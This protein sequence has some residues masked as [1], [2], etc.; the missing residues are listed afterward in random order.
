MQFENYLEMKKQKTV[1]VE[2][3]G[4]AG[5]GKTTVA[6]LLMNELRKDGYSVINKYRHS[7]LHSKRPFFCI[8]YSFSLY[9]KVKKYAD[10][11]VPY[12]KNR[13]YVHWANH[14]VRMYNTIEKY[15][16]ADFA[17]I[18]EAIIQFIVAMGLNDRFPQSDL[19]DAVVEKIKFM[20]VSFIRVDC[21]NNLEAS[22]ERIKSRPPKGMYYENWPKEELMS[23]LQAETYNF[24]Y[25]RTVF[26][27]V[28]PEQLVIS[29]DTLDS[30]KDNALKI[31]EIITKI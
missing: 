17:I 9:R 28:Y 29:I 18:D 23:Q 16:D 26:S 10:S 4:L 7:I 31:K 11:I 30:P 25:I 2:F 22:Y 6:N 3:N 21:K 20:G 1:I 27:R 14:Y 8:P 15:C 5:L 12:R 13:I 19:M 24:E